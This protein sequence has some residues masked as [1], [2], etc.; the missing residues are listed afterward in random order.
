MHKCWVSEYEAVLDF[1][2]PKTMGIYTSWISLGI[3]D[4]QYHHSFDWV[5]IV[6]SSGIKPIAA[7]SSFMC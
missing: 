6:A 2:S 1:Q 3:D 5:L 4:F 7:W